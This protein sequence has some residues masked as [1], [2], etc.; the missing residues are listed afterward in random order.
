M[1]TRIL[2]HHGHRKVKYIRTLGANDFGAFSS[3][4]NKLYGKYI[5][6][7]IAR[8]IKEN[9]MVVACGSWET[10]EVCRGFCW[11]DLRKR[12][13]LEGPGIEEKIILKCIFKKWNGEA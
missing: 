1:K 7:T 5:N 13:D 9:E 3:S 4:E 6:L 11:G 8:V 2:F 12:D 10:E